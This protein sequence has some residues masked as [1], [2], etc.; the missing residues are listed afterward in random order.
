MY[1]P[2]IFRF[3]SKRKQSTFIFD[4]Q[5]GNPGHSLLEAIVL[6]QTNC[7]INNEELS[8][9]PKMTQRKL[10]KITTLRFS[11]STLS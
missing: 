11:N 2:L 3:T 5:G 4:R 10:T 8:L 7:S 1:N 6:E 9:L